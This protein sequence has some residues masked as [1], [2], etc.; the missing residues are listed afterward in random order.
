MN[1]DDDGR[2]L[3]A[4]IKLV[5]GRRFRLTTGELR[6]EVALATTRRG[7][8]VDAQAA[9]A[10]VL[11]A[12]PMPIR[13]RDVP[14]E[15]VLAPGVRSSGSSFEPVRNNFVLG[16]VGHSHA[17]EGVQ[18]SIGGNM[19]EHEMRGVQL[20]PGFNLTRGASRGLQIGA[21]ANVAL[22]EFRGAQLGDVTNVALGS[23][24]G[25]QVS[26]FNWTGPTCAAPRWASSTTTR[27]ASW[28]PRSA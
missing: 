3:S 27:A 20:A 28:A 1:I 10:D 8:P 15:G 9:G 21:G 22:S 23:M 17:L 12:T 5:E 13:Y 24:R 19:V 11:V 7:G 6:S 14:F 16:V 4:R 2:P 26:I 25:L 18:L